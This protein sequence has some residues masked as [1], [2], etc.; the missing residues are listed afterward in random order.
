MDTTPTRRKTIVAAGVGGLSLLAGCGG[1]SGSDESGG[2]GETN[3]S[4]ADADEEPTSNIVVENVAVTRADED[5]RQL[6]IDF[7]NNA[8]TEVTATDAYVTSGFPM[9]IETGSNEDTVGSISSLGSEKG[10]PAGETTTVVMEV[11][12]VQSAGAQERLLA[13]DGLNCPGTDNEAVRNITLVTEFNSEPTKTV[14][15]GVQFGGEYRSYYPYGCEVV[16][17]DSW[18]E[19]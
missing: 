1:S 7:R 12:A 8:E 10:L 19:V 3:S 17:V 14:Q 11:T 5:F 13:P 2:G 15:I 6:T 16:S 9:D 18:E 4:D